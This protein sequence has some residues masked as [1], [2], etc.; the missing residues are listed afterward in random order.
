MC[1]GLNKTNF[2]YFCNVQEEFEDHIKTHFPELQEN[3]F[4]LACSGGIDSVVLAHL[5]A[6]IQLNFAI[7]HCNFGLRG[8]ESK[9]DEDFVRA[10]AKELNAPFF[11]THFDTA[12]YV[13]KHKVSVLLAARELRYTWFY[14]IMKEQGY[15][16]LVTAHQAD[17]DLET[18]LINLSRGTGIQGLMGIPQRTDSISRPLLK[19]SREAILDYAKNHQIKWREDSSNK[20]TIYLRN[21]IRHQIIPHL[22]ALHPTFLD[23]FAK[24]RHYLMQTHALL[25]N[26]IHDLRDSLWQ[27]NT[28]CVK[29]PIASLQK[30]VPLDAYIYELFKPYGFTEWNDV[31]G[32]LTTMSGKEV[33]SKTHR[34]LRDR[35]FL[36]LGEI[37]PPQND[38]YRIEADQSLLE[39]PL[40]LQICEI[41]AIAKFSDDTLYVDQKALKYPLTVRKWQRSDYF[42]PY[43]MRHK[44]KLSKFFKDEKISVFDKERQWLLCSGNQIVWVMGRRSDDRFKVTGETQKII[45]FTIIE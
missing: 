35:D 41:D 27:S 44:K 9:G 4:L 13:E 16:T 5:C 31:L 26:Y 21:K 36:V 7:A 24:T 29:I 11:V 12:Y 14:K 43:G 8:M 6:E 42:Y 34:L 38:V 19:F 17:D 1:Q 15:N 20:K 25:E 3:T 33:R 39:Y 28:E 30:L 37:K 45:K 2:S 22:K 32:L 40:K 10:L 18:F 23:N